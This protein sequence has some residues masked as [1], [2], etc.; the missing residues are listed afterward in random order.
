MW[1]TTTESLGSRSRFGIGCSFM[2]V[3][4][5]RRMRVVGILALT[6]RTLAS[7]QLESGARSGAKSEMRSRPNVFFVERFS[8]G[9]LFFLVPIRVRN[10][11]ERGTKCDQTLMF[12]I[13]HDGP[14][15]V[16][17]GLRIILRRSLLHNRVCSSFVVGSSMVHKILHIYMHRYS[18]P[19]G[20]P[21]KIF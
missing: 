13:V 15:I 14:K 1:P 3:C 16:K 6:P 18:Y 2:C 10:R 12:K 5:K 9:G 11:V 19:L 4:T 17:D 21:Q 20:L 7:P 8:V